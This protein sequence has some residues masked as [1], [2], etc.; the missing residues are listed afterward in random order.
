MRTFNLEAGKKKIT[1]DLPYNKALKY[2][3][4]NK[5][6]KFSLIASSKKKVKDINRPRGINKYVVKSLKTK[7]NVVKRN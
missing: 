1:L 4:D 7:I 5:F 2:G 3:I 6:K